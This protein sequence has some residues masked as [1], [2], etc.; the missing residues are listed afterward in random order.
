MHIIVGLVFAAGSLG[1][2]LGAYQAGRVLVFLMGAA[3]SLMFGVSAG[4]GPPVLIAMAIGLPL[5]WCMASIP[6]WAMRANRA[7]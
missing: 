4:S 1:L 3:L 7:S 6:I 5:S 2:W